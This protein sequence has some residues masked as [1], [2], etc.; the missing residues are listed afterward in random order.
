M[1]FESDLEAFK[2]KIDQALKKLTSNQN[3]TPIAKDTEEIIRR[4]TRLGKG[5]DQSGG[6]NV[7]LKALA[8]S[9]KASRKRKQKRGL[10]SEKTSP[11]KS[12]LTETAQLLDSL[13]G[14]AINQLIE[15]K[16]TGARK[17]SKLSN[18]KVAAYQDS[19][20]RKFLNLSKQDIK[21]L[22]AVMQDSF[23]NILNSIFK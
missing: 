8:T 6:P 23:N 22:T 14:R 4:R 12:N 7:A 16:P 13:K 2:K 17:G 19:A 3:L 5:V 20:G 10:L 9:T 21:Q 11:N 15:V 1:S 18:S